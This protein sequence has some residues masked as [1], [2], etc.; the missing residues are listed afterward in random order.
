[1]L[2]AF[3]GSRFW[4]FHC[5]KVSEPREQRRVKERFLDF[6]DVSALLKMTSPYLTQNGVV[7]TEANPKKAW[8]TEAYIESEPGL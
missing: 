5:R 2:R 1:M 8:L 3:E 4:G 6:L 7:E